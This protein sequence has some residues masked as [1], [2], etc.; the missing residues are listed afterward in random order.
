MPRSVE[1]QS[2][3]YARSPHMGPTPGHGHGGG[4]HEWDYHTDVSRD[5]P[6]LADEE[7]G[8]YDDDEMHGTLHKVDHIPHEPIGDP[9]F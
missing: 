3:R 4:E 5:R 7:Y 2:E 1:K 9:P 8:D 6:T